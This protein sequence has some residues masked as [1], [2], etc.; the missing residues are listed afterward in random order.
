MK[1]NALY[2]A[3]VFCTTSA[4]R[5]CLNSLAITSSCASFCTGYLWKRYANTM[6]RTQSTPSQVVVV[7]KPGVYFGA[8]FFGH[9]QVL[10]M[11][12]ALPMELI[13]AMAMARFSAG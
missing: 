7:A 4:S 8:S 6:V 11:L 12:E 5:R 13:S 9:S 2:H 10:Y 3:L 1:N